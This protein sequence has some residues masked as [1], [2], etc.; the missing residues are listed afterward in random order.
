MLDCN[1]AALVDGVVA[2][3]AA[4][5][6]SV[7]AND[8]VMAIMQARERGEEELAWGLEHRVRSFVGRHAAAE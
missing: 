6:G 5:R 3:M 4:T 7:T 8:L 1:T 2:E